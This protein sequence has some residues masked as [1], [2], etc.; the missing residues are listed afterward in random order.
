MSSQHVREERQKWWWFAVGALILLLLYYLGPVLTPF[1]LA[2]ILAYI[3]QPLVEK[4]DRRMPRTLAVIL[5]ML[6]VGTILV[7]LMLVVMP[8][9]V[10]ELI[11]LAK[12]LPGWLQK[13]N[14]TLAPWLNAKLGTDVQL[15]PAS[16]KESISAAL[17]TRDDLGARVLATLR[18]GGLG[19]LGLFANLVLV[20]VVMFFLLRDWRSFI[21]R[22]EQLI[23]R[24]WHDDVA[25]FFCEADYALGQ[26]LHGQILVLLVMSAFYTLTLWATGL[27][28]F[29]PI[30]VVTG[31]LTFIPFVGAT[32]GFVLATLAAAMQFDDMTRLLWVWGVF[33]LGQ[34]IEGNFVT[35]KLV[36][37]AIGLH[38]V[39]V[40][41][42]L[43]AFGQLFGFTGLLIALPA[44]AVLLVGLRKLRRKYLSSPFYNN[45]PA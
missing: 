33:F 40:I 34:I 19:L 43:L 24:A 26:Y 23:P 39:A 44:S 10:K 42:A 7:V 22:F 28:F 11:T 35:P 38:P 36:G 18:M 12:A 30:G 8:L 4:L 25:G 14:E 13:L 27:H 20:P 45:P 29:L 16:I 17:Q 3:C 37:D 41:F 1:V 15:D 5:V 32:V 2:A 6:G 31:M 9:L 21:S